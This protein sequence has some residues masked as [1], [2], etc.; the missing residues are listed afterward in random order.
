MTDDQIAQLAY[1]RIIDAVNDLAH[2]SMGLGEALAD[3][4]SDLNEASADALIEKLRVEI[5]RRRDLILAPP[6]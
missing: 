4:D 1:D 5:E 3:V 2:D 6:S